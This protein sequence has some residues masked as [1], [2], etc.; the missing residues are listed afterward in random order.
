MKKYLLVLLLL[1]LWMACQSPSP[2]HTFEKVAETPKAFP[3][4]LQQCL[5]AH[6]GLDTWKQFGQLQFEMEYARGERSSHMQSIIDLP[7]RHERITTDTYTL[8]YDGTSFWYAADS[9]SENRPDA[10]FQINLQFYFFAL[11][12]VLADPGVN[13]EE[14]APR[15]LNEVTYDVLKITF[16]QEVGEA[17]GDQYILYL[18]PDTHRLHLLLYS[19]TYFNE[20]NAEKYN[21]S[22]YQD[23]QEVGGLWVPQQTVSYRWDSEQNQL[24][25]MRGR[26]TFSNVRF[27]TEVPDPTLFSPPEGAL[28]D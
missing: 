12:F 10:R 27:A 15:V 25:D 18:H 9:I 21:A 6:G 8:G 1:P 22:L 5:G 11:P 17:P 3:R 24:G 14:L 28:M 20:E 23:W 19:V 4:L 16:G 2:T 7:Q 13:Y 26:K